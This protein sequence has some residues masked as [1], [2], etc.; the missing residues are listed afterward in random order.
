MSQR[1]LAEVSSDIFPKKA[2]RN[3]RK[4]RPLRLRMKAL[5][6]LPNSF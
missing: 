3:S 6:G 2:S 4:E 1:Y 5:A